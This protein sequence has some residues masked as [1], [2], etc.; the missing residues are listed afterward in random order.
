M[1]RKLQKHIL[2][3][4][5]NPKLRRRTREKLEAALVRSK[6]RCAWCEDRPGGCHNCRIFR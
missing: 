1:S 4:L 5:V 6:P 3:A 2:T